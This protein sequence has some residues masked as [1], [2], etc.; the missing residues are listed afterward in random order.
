M[1]RLVYSGD[2]EVEDEEAADILVRRL[3]AM[4][5]TRLRAAWHRDKKMVVV[6]L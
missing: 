5:W 4:R 6:L 1:R 3:G 2:V